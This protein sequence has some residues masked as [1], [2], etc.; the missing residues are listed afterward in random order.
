MQ[1]FNLFAI[2]SIFVIISNLSMAILFFIH[3]KKSLSVFLWSILCIVVSTWGIGGLIFSTTKSYDLAMQGFKF[4]YIG[5]VMTPAIFFHFVCVHANL[6]KRKEII[7]WYL[8]CT[9]I[10]VLN[11]FAEHLFLCDLTF[12]YNEFYWHDWFKQ[13]SIVYLLYFIPVTL[14]LLSYTIF[15]IIREIKRADNKCQVT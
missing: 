13:K 4:S 7:F 1:N 2:S 8:Y 11:F 3:R 15:L 10:L 14:F 5:P 12:V 9:F 6:G